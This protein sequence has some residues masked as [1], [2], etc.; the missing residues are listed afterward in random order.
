MTGHAKPLFGT[1]LGPPCGLGAVNDTGLSEPAE[2]AERIAV[3]PAASPPHVVAAK[4][5]PGDAA[6]SK[7]LE[8]HQ[9]AAERPRGETEIH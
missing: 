3:R 9:K 2:S 7:K 1:V 6:G 8:L 4:M 5:V